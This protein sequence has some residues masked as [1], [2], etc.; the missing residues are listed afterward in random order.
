MSFIKHFSNQRLT[1]ISQ[2]P[3]IQNWVQRRG[4][5]N[6]NGKNSV[7]CGKRSVAF[8]AKC[9][10]VGNADEWRIAH[11]Q[12]QKKS[13]HGND[14]L[15]VLWNFH[16]GARCLQAG[17]YILDLGGMMFDK[18]K[19]LEIRPD[20]RQQTGNDDRTSDGGDGSRAQPKSGERTHNWKQPSDSQADRHPLT[21]DDGF[22]SKVQ[23][24]R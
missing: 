17:C 14:R 9:Y 12:N 15:V 13:C 5:I 1:K 23:V 7:S 4:G 11:D 20:V 2:S 8:S 21:C 24:H 16:C 18:T 3:T 22:V 6:P 19:Y 10:C